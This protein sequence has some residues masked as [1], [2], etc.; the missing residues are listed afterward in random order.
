MSGTTG[1][2]VTMLAAVQDRYGSTEVLEVRQV[3]RPTVG[4]GE[5]LV[6]VH[7]ASVNF[8][9]WTI[10]QGRPAVMRLAFGLSRPR[11][12]I[13]GRD[14]AGVVEAI[15]EG[16]TDFRPGD[17]VYGEVDGGTFAEFTVASERILAPMPA[18]L[19]FEQAAV[20]PLA[21]GTAQQAVQLAGVAPGQAVLVIGASGGVGSFAV[22]LATARGARV[23]AVCSARNAEQA[24]ALGAVDVVD[25]ADEDP[26]ATDRRY[27]A[28]LD[29]VG[30]RPL[31]ALRRTLTSRGVLVLSSGRG[32]RMLGPIPRLLGAILR[33]PFG[34]GS[35]R[36]LAAVQRRQTLLELTELLESG[37]ISPVI[38]ASYPLTDTAAALRR[39]G[40]QHARSKF[41]IQMEES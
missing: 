8:A 32:G 13:R 25:Y 26:T 29:F 3:P 11:V 1:E 15:G 5:V 2:S 18:G 35:L 36:P 30:D 21:G 12:P 9:D 4:A 22:Q 7:A 19:R 23:T 6:R 20:V 38:E 37:A 16:V 40:E 24:R 14:V 33:S 34:N 39:F 17:R 10:L 41:V 31:G 27:D 28:I